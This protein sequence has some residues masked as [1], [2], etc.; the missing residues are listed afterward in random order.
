M[1]RHQLLWQVP[2]PTHR[3][4]IEYRYKDTEVSC[5]TIEVNLVSRDHTN[6]LRWRLTTGDLNPPV[7][8]MWCERTFNTTARWHCES[9]SPSNKPADLMALRTVWLPSKAIVFRGGWCV[10]S[11]WSQRV[12][13]TPIYTSDGRMSRMEQ[14]PHRSY[15]LLIAA[16]RLDSDKVKNRQQELNL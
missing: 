14:T 12:H 15:S 5:V 10:Q 16:L 13:S 2:R 3:W 4:W 1:Q 6:R 8:R 9:E 11:W 7:T